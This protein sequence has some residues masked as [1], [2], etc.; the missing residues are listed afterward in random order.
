KPLSAILPLMLDH[1]RIWVFGARP[2]QQLPP[3]LVRE[4]SLALLRHFTLI[5]THQ[6]H[7]ILVTLWVRR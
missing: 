4:E 3:G 7:N 5:G 2:S 6:F 1:R